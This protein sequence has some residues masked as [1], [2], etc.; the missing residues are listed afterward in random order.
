M[1]WL[2]SNIDNCYHYTHYLKKYLKE[3][4]II[5]DSK[6]GYSGAGR[7]ILKKSKKIDLFKSLSVY[8]IPNHRHNAEIK[9]E[10]SIFLKI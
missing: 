8:G 5:I 2:L 10:L 7:G 9:Q 3:N 4:K 6:S 1:S